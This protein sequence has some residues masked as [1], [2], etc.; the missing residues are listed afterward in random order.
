MAPLPPKNQCRVD[1]IEFPI[2]YFLVLRES[3]IGKNV[4]YVMYFPGEGHLIHNF[5]YGEVNAEHKRGT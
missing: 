1:H 4:D 3:I 2:L 5:N